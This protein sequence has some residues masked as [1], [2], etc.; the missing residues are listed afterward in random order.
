MCCVEMLYSC[1][2][3]FSSRRRHTRCALVTGVQTCALPISNIAAGNRNLMA[4]FGQHVAVGTGGVHPCPRGRHARM[5]VQRFGN[6]FDRR[7]I[8]ALGKN[9]GGREQ[10]EKRP[11]DN[12]RSHTILPR[13]ETGTACHR[14]GSDRFDC[15]TAPTSAPRA[16]SSTISSSARSEEHTS[17][18]HA[19]IP[20]S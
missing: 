12:R 14:N 18:L 20:I 19:L 1:V 5:I 8:G 16:P 2:F 11:E 10:C 3:F 17:E 9:P 4:S 13:A 6:L 7:Q 15:V